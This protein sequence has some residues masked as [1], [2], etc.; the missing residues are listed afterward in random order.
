MERKCIFCLGLKN[1][2]NFEVMIN[3]ALYK[4]YQ[5]VY[6]YKSIINKFVNY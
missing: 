1:K 2:K 5:S 4:R 6:F 3:S